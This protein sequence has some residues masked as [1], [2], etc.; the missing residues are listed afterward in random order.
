MV[1]AF[2]LTTEYPDSC[3]EEV[4]ADKNVVSGDGK[5]VDR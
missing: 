1:M 3:M 2:D 4:G 5:L